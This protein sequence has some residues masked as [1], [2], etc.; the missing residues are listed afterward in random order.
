MVH[1]G[2]MRDIAAAETRLLQHRAA[3]LQTLLDVDVRAALA[4]ISLQYFG[5]SGAA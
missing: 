2:Y 3:E 1:P 4:G 5:Q